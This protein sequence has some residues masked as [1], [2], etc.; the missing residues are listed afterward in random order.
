VGERHGEPE[1]KAHQ[2]QANIARARAR[3]L[4]SKY[5]RDYLFL[6]LRSFKAAI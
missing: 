3:A 6:H 4:P 1:D 2:Q 5:H